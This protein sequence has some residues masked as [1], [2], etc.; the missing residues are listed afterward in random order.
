MWAGDWKNDKRHGRGKCKF[1]DGA[2]FRGEWEEDGWV[3]TSAEPSLCNAARKGLHQSVA[4]ETAGFRI[5]VRIESGALHSR[6]DQQQKATGGGNRGL[7]SGG[8]AGRQ[9]PIC[10]LSIMTS[11]FV[12]HHS[13]ILQRFAG[14]VAISPN[15]M[16]LQPIA[17]AAAG[18]ILI[19][20]LLEHE[21]N[22]APCRWTFK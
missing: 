15:L 14:T 13:V 9:K 3:Q 16:M 10:M 18:T 8:Q 20:I 21:P 6:C 17:A 2:K 7:T 5:E 1:A 19:F 4:G 22:H 11:S 12:L